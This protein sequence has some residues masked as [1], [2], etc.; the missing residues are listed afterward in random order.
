[1]KAENFVRKYK[2]FGKKRVWYLIKLFFGNENALNDLKY[3]VINGA[4]LL[5]YFRLKGNKLVILYYELF[6]EDII[7]LNLLK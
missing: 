6:Q 2:S 4:R 7:I 5:I 3:N 1:M